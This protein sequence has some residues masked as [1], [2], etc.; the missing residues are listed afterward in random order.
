MTRMI[1]LI[2]LW[3]CAGGPAMAGAWSRETGGWFI[4]LGTNYALTDQARRPVYWDPTI[5]LEYGLRPGTTIGIDGYS[6]DGGDELAGLLYWRQTFSAADARNQFALTFG[7]GVRDRE[8][9]PTEDIT[10]IGL[11]WGRGT[12]WGWLAV[13][14][15]ATYSGRTNRFDSKLDATLGY[16][17]SDRWSGIMQLQSGFG[18]EGDFYA[19]AAPSAVLRINGNLRMEFGAV[20]SLTGDYGSAL[21]AS[22]WLEF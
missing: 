18:T 14:T 17:F 10:R 4:S 15:A 1:V 22:V 11:S 3:L 13:D 21:R 6:A 12:N 7:L 8:G 2:G 16:N 5:Y 19:K 20:Q 9:F